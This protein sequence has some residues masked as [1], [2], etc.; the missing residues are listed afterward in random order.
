[1]NQPVQRR[2]RTT[3]LVAGAL[4][5]AAVT[6]A[7]AP[8]LAHDR[9]AG[10]GSTVAGTLRPGAPLDRAGL[11]AALAE[12]PADRYT[13]A[14]VEVGGR[15]AHWS[16]TTGADVSADARFRIGSISKVFTAT[17][18]L[19][20]AAEGRLDLDDTVQRHLPGLLPD[21]YRPVT[22]GQLLDHTSGLPGGG[23]ELGDGSARWFAEHRTSSWAPAEVV[24]SAVAQPMSFEPGTAQQY[25][26]INTFVAGMLVEKV[27]GRGFA[28]ELQRRITRPLGLRDT[29]LPAAGEL[30]LRGPHNRAH[31]DVPGADGAPATRIEVT[32]QSAWPW[33]EGGMVSTPADLERFLTALL[34]GRLLPP[35]QQAE[36]FAVP[37]LPNLR[38]RTCDIGPAAGRACFS[39][40]LMRTTLPNGTVLWGKTGSRPGYTNGVFATRDL[41]RTVVYSFNPTG[42]GGADLDTIWRVVTTAYGSGQK[43]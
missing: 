5:A 40:G 13:G 24:A 38:N 2:S 4:L 25:N 3:A 15:G 43:W 12:L 39:K 32:E 9:P 19:Q 11:T 27:T 14:L 23:P 10:P 34:R 36:L 31:L 30:G 37:D 42:I 20:L 22:V 7:G 6:V 17:L 21:S 28:E 1:M 8:A 18:V 16:G 29:Y 41:G 35:A 33:A 26:G